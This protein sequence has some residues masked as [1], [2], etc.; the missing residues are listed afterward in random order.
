MKI[1]KIQLTNIQSWDSDSPILELSPDAM[2]V[3]VAPSE[4]GKSVLIKT[5]KEMCFANNWGYTHEGL[6]R[7]GCKSGKAMFIFENGDAVMFEILPKTQNYFVLEYER[8][9]D[10]NFVPDENNELKY[11]I[12][13]YIFNDLDVEI[14]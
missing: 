4:T 12:D 5:I 11:R 8:D 6:I 1:V 9:E 3:I 10:G 13:K 14:P 7:R 2:N